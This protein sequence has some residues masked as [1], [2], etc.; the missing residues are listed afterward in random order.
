VLSTIGLTI[1][2]RS[3]PNLIHSLFSGKRSS[4]FVI[5]KTKKIADVNDMMYVNKINS[6]VKK[7]TAKS[8]NTRVKKY[9]NFLFDGSSTS[10]NFMFAP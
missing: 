2:A 8:T 1:I 10:E 3:R 5:E 7:Y 6:L 4:A 9:P